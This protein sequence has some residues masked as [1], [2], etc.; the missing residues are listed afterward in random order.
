M[1]DFGPSLSPL[2]Y[3]SLPEDI[4]NPMKSHQAWREAKAEGGGV[5]GWTGLKNWPLVSQA[6]TTINMKWTHQETPSNFV[7]EKI[8]LRDGSISGSGQQD[9]HNVS[10]V[11][12]LRR[13]CSIP[14]HQETP[15]LLPGILYVVQAE[16]DA[17]FPEER[18]VKN[19]Q[20]RL[21]HK[22]PFDLF[23]SSLPEFPPRWF[24][25]H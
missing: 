17:P 18:S 1:G 19:I 5:G 10:Y 3:F 4:N 23:K 16:H 7:S 14:N 11:L 24:F 13:S 22:Q 15:D 12:V 8:K 25:R 2:R 21:V 20:P 6:H 9:S